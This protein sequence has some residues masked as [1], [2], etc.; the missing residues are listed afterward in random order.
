M[1]DW[2][3]IVAKHLFPETGVACG[4]SERS[5]LGIAS[6]A[7]VHPLFRIIISHYHGNLGGMDKAVDVEVTHG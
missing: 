2:N 3:R 7:S 6:H 5:E 1:A 4:E